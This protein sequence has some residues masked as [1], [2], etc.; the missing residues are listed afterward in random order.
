MYQVEIETPKGTIT[1]NIWKI[2]ELGK[3]LVIHPDYTGV[4][5]KRLTKGAKIPP[6]QT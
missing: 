4:K 3:Y 2:E 5:V 6:K 1:F